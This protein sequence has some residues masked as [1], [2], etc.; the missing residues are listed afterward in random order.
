M[1]FHIITTRRQ[2]NK[3]KSLW[4]MK[5]DVNATTHV[6]LKYIVLYCIYPSYK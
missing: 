3:K 2:F 6:T 4:T 5:K 1:E